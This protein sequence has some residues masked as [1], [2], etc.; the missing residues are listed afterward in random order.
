MPSTYAEREMNSHQRG[1]FITLMLWQGSRL[2]NSDVA[3]L[4]GMTRRNAAYMMDALSLTFP[5]VKNEGK[6]EWMAKDND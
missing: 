2:S 3:R 6:W 4:C 1:G 5:L